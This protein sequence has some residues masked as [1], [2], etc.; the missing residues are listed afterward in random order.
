MSLDHWNTIGLVSLI[1]RSI[2]SS[3]LCFY[4]NTLYHDSNG[5]FLTIVFLFVLLFL[6]Q[7]YVLFS[8]QV[9]VIDWLS[10]IVGSL[11]CNHF[12][13]LLRTWMEILFQII[14][15]IVFWLLSVVSVCQ[16]CLVLVLCRL[17]CLRSTDNHNTHYMISY[18]GSVL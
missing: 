8:V 2:Y 1:F 16:H 7:I 15:S 3:Y 12:V 14:V 10:D 18:Y 4:A 6:V 11:F 17:V 13:V 5:S 9:I